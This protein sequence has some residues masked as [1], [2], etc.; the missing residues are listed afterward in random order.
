[1]IN[2]L[3]VKLEQYHLAKDNLMYN[4]G[5]VEVPPTNKELA[6]KLNELIEV[7]NRLETTIPEGTILPYFSDKAPDGW[8]EIS[9]GKT[10]L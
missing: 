1:M 4:P 6:D 10:N 7:V 9:K 2:K 3:E 8:K 5:I